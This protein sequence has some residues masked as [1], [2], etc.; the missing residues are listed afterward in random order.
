MQNIHESVV[1]RPWNEIWTNNYQQEQKRIT[2]FLNRNNHNANIYHIGSTSIKG[3]LSKPIID[4]LICP[5]FKTPLLDIVFDL[6]DAGYTCLG[7]CGKPG[8]FFLIMGDKENQT[9]YIHLCYETHPVA[10]DQLLFHSMLQSSYDVMGNYIK[11]KTFLAQMYPDNRHMYRLIKGYFIEGVLGS[12]RK[13]VDDQQKKS[14]GV[15]S[16]EDKNN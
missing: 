10:Q 9:Y 15:E 3:I 12:Y 16:N 5:E 8:R 4:I 6:E 13:A 11:Q 1:L 2:F 14:K 7:E